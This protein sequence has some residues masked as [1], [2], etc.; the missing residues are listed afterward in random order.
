M[1]ETK[2][3]QLFKNSADAY[4][5]TIDESVEQG[6]SEDCFIKAVNQA[7]N[8]IPCCTELCYEDIES[9]KCLTC[10]DETCLDA[11]CLQ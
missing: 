10:G 1:N 4:L 3:R 11:E 2:L 5:N 8:F 6:M 9:T 7:I